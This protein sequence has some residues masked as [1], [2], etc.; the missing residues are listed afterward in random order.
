MSEA[1]GNNIKRILASVL[2]LVLLAFC[3]GCQKKYDY[4][5][6]IT[7][8]SRYL[9]YFDVPESL[10][11]SELDKYVVSDR[12]VYY[13]IK[14]IYPEEGDMQSYDLLII[15]NPEFQTIRLS[16]FAD[17]EYGFDADIK[18]KWDEL[19]QSGADMTFSV[20]EILSIKE[21]AITKR[22]EEKKIQQAR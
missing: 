16:F 12:D 4:D 15:Y 21:A 2:L 5:D 10:D 1:I 9:K 20:E 3:V 22:Q 7:M 6:E 17:M 11:I 18:N 19:Q 8:L 14:W 13:Y